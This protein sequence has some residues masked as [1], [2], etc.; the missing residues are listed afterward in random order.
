MLLAELY[1][2]LGEEDVVRGLATQITRSE[3]TRSALAAEARGDSGE[4]ER[5]F[6]ETLSNPGGI[7][8][9]E[10]QLAQR[11]RRDSLVLLGPEGWQRLL[12]ETSP[13]MQR[14]V[15]QVSLGWRRWRPG[16]PLLPARPSAGRCPRP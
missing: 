12:E 3:A 11:A 14:A 16:R 8:E 5:L 9:W 15:A 4:A 13:M 7:G 6:S 1:G 2:S 10:R